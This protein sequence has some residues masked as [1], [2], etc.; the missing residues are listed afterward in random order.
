M[1]AGVKDDMLYVI[2]IKQ[3]GWLM[4]KD[5]QGNNG[6]TFETMISFNYLLTV[7]FIT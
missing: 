4:R 5:S 6:I 7:K 2:V 3:V 1:A